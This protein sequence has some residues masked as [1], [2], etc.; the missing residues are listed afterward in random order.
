MFYYLVHILLIHLSALAVNMMVS[1]ATHQELYSVAPFVKV[2]ETQRWGLPLL[3][4]VWAAN[5]FVLYF[6]CRW[7]ASYKS[8]HPEQ[9]WLKYL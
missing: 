2:P 9:R 4:A 1:G 5:I 8:D 3:Y 6:A 7:Y